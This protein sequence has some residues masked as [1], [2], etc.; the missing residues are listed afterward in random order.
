MA[1]EVRPGGG[2]SAV[3]G[4]RGGGRGEGREGGGRAGAG[5]VVREGGG[6]APAVACPLAEG[7][8]EG[9]LGVLWAEA[10]GIKGAGRA[11]VAVAACASAKVVVLGV[12][13]VGEARRV[14]PREE[15]VAARRVRVVKAQVEVRERRWFMQPADRR[16]VRLRREDER[17]VDPVAE[18]VQRGGVGLGREEEALSHFRMAHPNDAATSDVQARAEAEA[19]GG[20]GDG[21]GLRSLAAECRS[22]VL[23]LGARGERVTGMRRVNAAKARGQRGWGKDKFTGAPRALTPLAPRTQIDSG[24]RLQLRQPVKTLPLPSFSAQ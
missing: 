16:R 12:G 15:R 10:K 22:A 4:G 7:L 11:Q 1:E 24:A 5:E 20:E 8:E 3:A 17:R 23:G 18:P 21:R 19:R 2:R 9:L 6:G 14:E 13:V